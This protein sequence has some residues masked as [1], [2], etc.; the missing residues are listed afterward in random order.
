MY[1]K[2][3]RGVIFWFVELIAPYAEM[4]RFISQSRRRRFGCI[5][6]IPLRLGGWLGRKHGQVCCKPL[7]A[8]AKN[9][10]AAFVMVIA[11]VVIHC[12]PHQRRKHYE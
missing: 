4:F 11:N 1:H 6:P 5:M 7:A 2:A 12:S 9:L 10:K 8:C 3:S